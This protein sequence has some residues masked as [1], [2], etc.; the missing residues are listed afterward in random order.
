MEAKITLIMLLWFATLLSVLRA[1]SMIFSMWGKNKIK[2][3][4]KIFVKKQGDETGPQIQGSVLRWHITQRKALISNQFEHFVKHTIALMLSLPGSLYNRIFNFATFT[5]L[6]K[7]SK[8]PQAFLSFAIQYG[9][10]C[11]FHGK[12]LTYFYMVGIT[13]GASWTGGLRLDGLDTV[14]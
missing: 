10:W 8:P 3:L 2:R 6:K 13:C 1:L 11:L 14:I 7:T 4:V 9:I 12:P 5:S